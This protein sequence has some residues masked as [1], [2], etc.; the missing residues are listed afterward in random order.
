MSDPTRRHTHSRKPRRTSP[1]TEQ[2]VEAIAELAREGGQTSVS[3]IAE[4]AGVSRPAAS[5]SVRDLATKELVEHRAYGHVALTDTG[6]ALAEQLARKHD[7]LQRFLQDVLG[8]GPEQAD[9]EA[10]RLEHLVGDGLAH[11]LGT[12]A[13]FLEREPEV[14]DRWAA[15]RDGRGQA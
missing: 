11:R 7:M 6:R 10:C 14:R 9:E 5:R 1:T 4:H 8:Y 15:Y 2:Y 12:L 3:D 13:E